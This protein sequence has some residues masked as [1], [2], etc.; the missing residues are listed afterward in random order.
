VG[1][2]TV[3][4]AVVW[5]IGRVLVEW[6]L[7]LIY[8][9]AIPD[10]SERQRFVTAIVSEQWHMQHDTGVPFAQMVAAR[11]AEFPHYADLIALY[12]IHWLDSIPGP[13][14]GTHDL[15]RRLTARDVP[16]YAITNFGAEAWA[17]FRPTFPILDH[18]Q[19][20]VVSGVE[21]MV[22]PGEEIFYLA[23]KRFGRSPETMLFIDDSAANVETARRL[24]W[25]A[26]HFVGDAA[27]LKAE[28]VELG[29]LADD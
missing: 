15:I 19:D 25:Q 6:D 21:R 28:M 4:E 7:S 17:L 1:H 22:K 24:G 11:Q 2:G 3:I 23:A 14:A 16:Q 9:D 18:M 13:V 26:F 10:E 5:D 20:I 27:A 8:R 12:A 29:L